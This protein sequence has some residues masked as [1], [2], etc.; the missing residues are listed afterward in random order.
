MQ[1]L[2]IHVISD[3]KHFSKSVPAMKPDKQLT[4]KAYSF[5]DSQTIFKVCFGQ[6]LTVYIK[7]MGSLHLSLKQ[8]ATRF[9]Q[10]T[11]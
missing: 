3:L 9:I 7:H 8:R 1:V 6:S 4:I 10:N 11:D 5:S 2:R